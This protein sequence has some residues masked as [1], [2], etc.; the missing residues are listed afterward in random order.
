MPTKAELEAELERLRQPS[1]EHPES[2]QL[3]AAQELIASA[4][5]WTSRLPESE[6]WRTAARRWLDEYSELLAASI[7]ERQEQE[8]DDQESAGQD[9]D[10]GE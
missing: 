8:D 3:H 1:P 6:V 9:S 5:D 10:Q 7:A 4:A 2:D